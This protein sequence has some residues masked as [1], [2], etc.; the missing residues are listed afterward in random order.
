VLYNGCIEPW[1]NKVLWKGYNGR[2]LGAK[3]Q[4]NLGIAAAKCPTG[5]NQRWVDDWYKVC[6]MPDYKEAESEASY[7][8]N[9][10]ALFIFPDK[11]RE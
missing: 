2:G 9:I 1:Y 3:K 8:A 10:S 7:L 11:A 5:F 4:T 6:E